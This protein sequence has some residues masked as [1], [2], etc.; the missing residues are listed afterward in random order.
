[1]LHGLDLVAFNLFCLSC[2]MGKCGRAE[3]V[4]SVGIKPNKIIKGKAL[5][6]VSVKYVSPL[7]FIISLL[8]D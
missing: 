5:N 3:P 4:P 8:N 6:S 1:M 7:S 2:L